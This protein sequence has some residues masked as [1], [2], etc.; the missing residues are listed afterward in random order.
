MLRLKEEFESDG[1]QRKMLKLSQK[2]TQHQTESSFLPIIY[3]M[4]ISLI[5]FVLCVATQA[6]G[7]CKGF[8]FSLLRRLIGISIHQND[9][10][11]SFY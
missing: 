2:A 7:Q 5:V 11:N 4:V 9:Q 6:E 3:A 8:F 1:F 10:L